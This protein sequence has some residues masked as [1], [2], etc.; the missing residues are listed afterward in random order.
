M[1]KSSEGVSVLHE[2]DRY[3]KGIRF[4]CVSLFGLLLGFTVLVKLYLP[5]YTI[6]LVITALAVSLICGFLAMKIGE[7]FWHSLKDWFFFG[8]N[9]D[10]YSFQQPIGEQVLIANPA[11]N[12]TS[13]NRAIFFELF[14]VAR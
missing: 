4:G 3:E 12:G 1:I 11:L 14:G 7:R 8:G 13:R 10:N 9:N 2:P 6:F 5:E